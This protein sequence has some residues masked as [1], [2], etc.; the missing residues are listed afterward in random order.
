[1]EIMT[2]ITV[3]T[4]A[5]EQAATCYICYEDETADNPYLDPSPCSCTGSIKL[6][7]E[8]FKQ[9]NKHSSTCGICK[10]K[11]GAVDYKIPCDFISYDGCR[12]VGTRMAISG[13]FIGTITTYYPGGNKYSEENY[14]ANGKLHGKSKHYYENGAIKEL[15]YYKNGELYGPYVIYY[16]SGIT[17]S[18]IEYDENEYHGSFVEYFEDGTPSVRGKYNSGNRDGEFVKFYENGMYYS[19]MT[20]DN[21]TL[22]GATEYYYEDGTLAESLPYKNGYIHGT[23]KEFNED[24]ILIKENTYKN[25]TKID[26]TCYDNT[27]EI[28]VI[29]N[30][31]TGAVVHF[32]SRLKKKK[33]LK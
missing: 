21:G 31:E 6:H 22:H 19:K 25:G 2:P 33:P 28:L 32:D 10:S 11:Y 9:V 20:Y 24:G 5:T 26:E 4:V 16:E 30:Y 8:C 15:G 12:I 7:I 27:G 23:C 13:G 18:M 29:R 14:N 17:K 1:M 3:T